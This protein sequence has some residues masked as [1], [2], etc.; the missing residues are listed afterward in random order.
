M[1]RDPTVQGDSVVVIGAG[2][3]GLAAAEAI[4]RRGIQVRIIERAKRAGRNG[5]MCPQDNPSS[6]VEPAAP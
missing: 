5:S 4:R 2:A 6:Q 3:S 1:S